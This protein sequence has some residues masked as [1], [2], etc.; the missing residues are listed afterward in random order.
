MLS[1]VYLQL[2]AALTATMAAGYNMK[3]ENR[4]MKPVVLV[5]ACVLV[6]ADYRS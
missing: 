1:P 5:A 4:R 2:G 3:K 6:D